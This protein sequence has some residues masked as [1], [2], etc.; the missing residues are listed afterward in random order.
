[1]R[2]MA[3]TAAMAATTGRVRAEALRREPRQECSSQT[4]APAK[5][6]AMKSSGAAWR[7]SF[8]SHDRDFEL[9]D[10]TRDHACTAMPRCTAGCVPTAANQWLTFVNSFKSISA[11]CAVPPRD[12][13]AMSAIE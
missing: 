6:P 13:W 7:R 2:F 12:R 9:I 1:M 4:Q 3:G 8:G 10:P 5:A 11:I